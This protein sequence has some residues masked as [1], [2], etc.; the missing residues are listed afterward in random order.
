MAAGVPSDLVQYSG[1]L[2]LPVEI[3]C[4][5]YD[6]LLIAP[7]SYKD[8]VDPFSYR[9]CGND[10]LAI[11]FANERDND[12]HHLLSFRTGLH[13]AI[14]ATC[15]SIYH[16]ASPVLYAGNR[17]GMWFSNAAY[18]PVMI[19]SRNANL[20]RNILVLGN[21]LCQVPNRFRWDQAFRRC[22]NLRRVDVSFGFIVHG[23]EQAQYPGTGSEYQE[24]VF[25]FFK[26]LQLLL[27]MHPF[28]QFASSRYVAGQDR[29]H[30]HHCCLGV[31]LLAVGEIASG[32]D[33][34]DESSAVL[35][36]DTILDDLRERL[37]MRVSRRRRR[38][39]RQTASAS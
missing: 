20:L 31:S 24:S 39:V 30:T 29:H 36:L 28:L 23:G 14:L 18:F 38:T 27:K 22:S 32:R 35:D 6:I 8:Y 3:R 25:T 10:T 33:R 37:G 13:S 26:R 21:G 5:I 19:G 9:R 16:E 7:P 4:H 2:R 17:F 12:D 11:T 15:K 34:E 1:F